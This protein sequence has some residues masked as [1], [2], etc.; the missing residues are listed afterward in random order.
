MALFAAASIIGLRRQFVL[1]FNFALYASSELETTCVVQSGFADDIASK[2]T[3]ETY[4]PRFMD[5]SDERI[6]VILSSY[7]YVCPGEVCRTMYI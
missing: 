6:I 1:E 4:F 3:K 7:I 2:T 5:L